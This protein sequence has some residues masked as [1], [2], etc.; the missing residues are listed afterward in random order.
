MGNFFEEVTRGVLG[1]QIS[2]ND[3]GDV[4]LWRQST[5]IEVKSSGIQSSYGFRL[6]IDQIKLYRSL[7]GFPFDNALYTFFSYRNRSLREGDGKRH[8]ELS[9][10]NDPLSINSYLAES[11]LWCVVV[12]FS[13]IR[14]WE[15][16]LPHSTNSVMGHLGCET[17]NVKTASV[18]ALANGGFKEGLESLSLNPDKFRKV[19][20]VVYTRLRLDLFREY[21][22]RFPITAIL[23]KE[24]SEVFQRML[25]RRGFS[26]TKDS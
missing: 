16:F 2:R 24:N 26:L 5:T 8:T 9:H 7:L 21:D 15:K 19:S 3:D 18:H 10:F 25:R 12:D 6:S 4:T 23:L 1:G 22:L 20:G 13:V 11:I 17:V 14:G